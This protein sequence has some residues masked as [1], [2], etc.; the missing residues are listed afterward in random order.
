M[1]TPK[2]Q[3][4]NHNAPHTDEE[5]KD[6]IERATA[7]YAAYMDALGFDWRNDPNSSNTPSRVAKAFVNDLA[8]GCYDVPPKVTSFD[9]VDRYD[10]MV[11]Q[12]NIVLTSLCS[13]HHLAFKGHAHVAYV[14]GRE[15][16]VIGLSKLNRV[17]DWFARRPQV[18][19]NLTMQ[20]HDY[21]NII[22][23]QNLGVAVMIEADH[24]C[25][26][27]RGIKHDST[28]R[29]SKISGCFLDNTNQARTEFYKFIEFAKV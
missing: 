5:K 18:Q 14:P 29:T 13:H 26:A 23:E 6:V 4:A 7:A 27:N 16:R 15:G 11:C 25:C 22:C 19:E 17:V 21:I 1:T 28:M 9:N 8:S 20:I 24:T 2:I 10:G 12:N 3:L